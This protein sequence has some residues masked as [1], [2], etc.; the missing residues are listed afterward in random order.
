MFSITPSKS[1]RTSHSVIS[2]H[3]ATSAI[4]QSVIKVKAG[5]RWIP[6]SV[7]KFGKHVFLC[8]PLVHCTYIQGFV[9][10]QDFLLFYPFQQTEFLKMPQRTI[11]YNISSVQLWRL[12]NGQSNRYVAVVWRQYATRETVATGYRLTALKCPYMIVCWH[13]SWDDFKVSASKFY[14]CHL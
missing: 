11:L 13:K 9:F 3:C 6:C 7:C 2:S 14:G 8:R 10:L 4:D 12:F 1:W 5:R